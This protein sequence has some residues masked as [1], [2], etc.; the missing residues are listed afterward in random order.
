MII[1]ATENN[2]YELKN[3]DMSYRFIKSIYRIEEKIRKP[4]IG[5]YTGMWQVFPCYEHWLGGVT[6][7]MAMTLAIKCQLCYG[8]DMTPAS[9]CQQGICIL[10]VCSRC[11][12]AIIT[13][14]SHII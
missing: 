8:D 7:A 4:F 10:E 11:K 12:F 3:W 9:K 6:H 5:L 14:L 1:I 2:D 13:R